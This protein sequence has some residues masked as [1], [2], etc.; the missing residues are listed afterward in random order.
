[1]FTDDV[2]VVIPGPV[3]TSGDVGM[4]YRVSDFSGMGGH[5][6]SSEWQGVCLEAGKGEAQWCFTLPRGRMSV[7]VR[8]VSKVSGGV[9][10]PSVA[11]RIVVR[12]GW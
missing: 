12:G 4:Q 6:P 1:M 11:K 5:V 9:S 3:T 7:E 8:A 2:L 10:E